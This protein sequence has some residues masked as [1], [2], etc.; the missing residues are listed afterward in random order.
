MKQLILLMVM[1]WM[2]STV[3]VQYYPE[4]KTITINN[5]GY[6]AKEVEIYVLN[7]QTYKWEYIQ[8]RRIPGGGTFTFAIGPYEYVFEYG[9]IVEGSYTTSVTKFGSYP[10]NLY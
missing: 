5:K 4:Q 8:T 6:Q 2:S 9:Y 1:A 7:K 10:A 3:T